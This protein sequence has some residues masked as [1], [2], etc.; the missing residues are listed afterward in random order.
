MR[1]PTLFIPHGGGPCFFMDTP[2]GWPKD[3]WDRMA[4]HLRGIAAG[5][6]ERPKAI[7]V[8]SGHWETERPTV[9]TAAKPTLLY[10]YYGFPE[11]TYR[12][13]YPAP[14]APALARR[15]RG[16]LAEAGFASDEDDARGLDHGVFVPLKVAFPDADV[17]VV[18]LSLQKDLDPAE[19]LAIGKAL[20]PLREEGELIVGSGMSYHN[21]PNLMSGRANEAA[22]RFD[23]WLAQAVEDPDPQARA[24][25]LIAW[26]EA[27]EAR[28]SH[29]DAEHLL[30]LMV[31]AGAAGDDRAVRTYSDRVLGKALSGFRFG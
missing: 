17:P 20:A 19:H 9:N 12:L 11:H 8:V 27:P 16:L 5:L 14:G 7:L 28:S 13:T 6:P 2:P 30:P 10:D 4:D 24:A 3:T 23:A 15:V 31:A 21:L 25:K 29:P 18:Q 1:M 22:A 26:E